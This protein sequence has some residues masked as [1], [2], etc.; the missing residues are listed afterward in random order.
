MNEQ[1]NKT[2]ENTNDNQPLIS[3]VDMI[4]LTKNNNESIPL[5]NNNNS[6]QENS[7]SNNNNDILLEIDKIIGPGNFDSVI[8]NSSSSAASSNNNLNNVEISENHFLKN[9]TSS[10]SDGSY[11]YQYALTKDT[12]N[13]P[14]LTTLFRDLF[15]IYTKL[16]FV[17][18]PFLSIEAKSYHIKQWDL[19]GPLLFNLFL[20]CTL[21][22][23]SNDKGQVVIL[24]FSIF[25]IGS[26]LV[27]LNAN[28]LG[29]KLS[30]FQI[31]CFFGYCLFPLNI[32][33]ILF[34]FTRFNDLLRFIIIGVACSWAIY[35]A[36][37]FLKYLSS[38]E[39]RYLVLYPAF[40]LYL[41]I[42]W[43]IFATK[44]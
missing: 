44:H 4:S 12:I 17:M 21:A 3:L 13:E 26:L 1:I 31:Y 18:N 30:I 28:F 2:S 7:N 40:L 22:I 10:I 6:N 8:S 33:A 19:W 35:S 43:L 23:N 14:I 41:Y 37:S 9:N 20:A 29:V 42:S 16:K 34:S 25:W 24:T 5:S 39:Q 15:L 32:V 11:S 36:S 27:Y 38:P